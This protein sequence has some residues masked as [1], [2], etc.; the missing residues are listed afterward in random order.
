[1]FCMIG[2]DE[3]TFSFDSFAG[4]FNVFM[5]LLKELQLQIKCVNKSLIS[6]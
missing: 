5:T 4:F 6:L 3:P 1:M 2:L